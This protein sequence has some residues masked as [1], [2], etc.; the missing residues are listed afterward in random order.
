M[1]AFGH[2]NTSY[3]HHHSL[4]PH[5]GTICRS[6]RH[7][8]FAH[9]PVAYSK[10][11]R[12]KRLGHDLRYPRQQLQQRTC[13]VDQTITGSSKPADDHIYGQAGCDRA[14]QGRACCCR[15]CAVPIRR[16]H[17]VCPHSTPEHMLRQPPLCRSCSRPQPRR[18][19]GS[20]AMVSHSRRAATILDTQGRAVRHERRSSTGGALLASVGG[21]LGRHRQQS[22][23]AAGSL[24]SKGVSMFGGRIGRTVEEEHVW[25]AN[26]ADG[27]GG[28]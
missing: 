28:G 10:C 1:I 3:H 17:R 27:R 8:P 2:L 5:A 23:G 11:I 21:S 15:F 25:R 22:S 13:M 16:A 18:C 14:N 24:T 6:L 26:R 20:P 4:R 19:A 9:F 12:R 7:S